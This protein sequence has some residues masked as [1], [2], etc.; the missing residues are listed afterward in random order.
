MFTGLIQSVCPVTSAHSTG[1]MMQLS[2]DLGRLAAEVKTGDSIAVNGVCLTATAAAA[3]IVSFDISS[4]TLTKSTLGKLRT[5]S[6]VNIELAIRPADRLGGH[7]VTGHIDGTATIKTI[8]RK[9]RFADITFTAEPQLLELMVIKGSVAVDGI[10][11]TIAALDKNSFTVAIIPETLG[12]TTLG[13]AKQGDLVNIETDIIIKAV[14]K[15]LEKALPGKNGLT[16]KKLKE[17]GF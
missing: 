9:D 15:L 5:Q 6:Q 16:V 14:K 3:G 17:L 7:F 13:R 8:E 1:R 2:V 10:S 4:E 11:L 12:K